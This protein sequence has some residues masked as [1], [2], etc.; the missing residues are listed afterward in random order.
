MRDEAASFAADL[1]AQGLMTTEAVE[2]ASRWFDVPETDV[3]TALHVWREL[4]V[5]FDP[6]LVATW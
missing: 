1:I 5:E 2:H 3:A 6:P 4:P